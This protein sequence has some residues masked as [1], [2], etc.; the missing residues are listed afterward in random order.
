VAKVISR[1]TWVEPHRPVP[2]TKIGDMDKELLT[3]GFGLP[4]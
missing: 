4:G 2:N 3:F 1:W